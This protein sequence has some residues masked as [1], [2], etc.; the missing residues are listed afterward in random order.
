MSTLHSE[1][2]LYARLTDGSDKPRAPW[3][4]WHGEEHKQSLS[5]VATIVIISSSESGDHTP[6]GKFLTLL[7]DLEHKGRLQL[8]PGYVSFLC[9][10][11]KE[12]TILEE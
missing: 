10:S 9:L 3:V 12:Q 7:N 5:S 11:A 4:C 8:C 2:N 1:M 6:A